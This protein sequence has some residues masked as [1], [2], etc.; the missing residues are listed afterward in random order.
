MNVSGFELVKMNVPNFVEPNTPNLQREV[1]VNDSPGAGLGVVRVN[2]APHAGAGTASDLV[3]FRGTL[4]ADRIRIA[5]SP[6]SGVEVF[7]LA[8]TVLANHANR[9]TVFGGDGDDVMDATGL[10][11]GTTTL[12][13]FGG[14]NPFN[15]GHISDGN[16]TLI[17]TPGDDDLVECR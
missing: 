6:A 4:G 15:S 8:E 11:A 13:E 3:L 16:D 2:F 14:G 12:T 10:A 7:G 5:G 1:E 9:L 17:G